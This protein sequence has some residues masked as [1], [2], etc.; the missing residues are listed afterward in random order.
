MADAT[1]DIGDLIARTALQD[2]TAFRR[3]YDASAPKLFAV[4]LRILKNRTDAEDAL[5]DIYVK[6]WN[7]ADR[8]AG[9]G[10]SPMAWLVAIARNHAIDKLRARRPA[11]GNIAVHD[12]LP[13][14]A[15][16]PEASAIAVSERGR[17]DDCIDRL[18]DA[19]AESVRSAYLE[20]YSYQELA[21]RHS[22]PLNTMRTWLRRSLMKLKECLEE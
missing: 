9:G 19:K 8:F 18:E 10:T 17:L 5:Q 1:A 2:R 12:D 11:H 21:D 3:L 7:R 15:R 4:A 13:D 22:V 14:P 6:I 16:S 20:G